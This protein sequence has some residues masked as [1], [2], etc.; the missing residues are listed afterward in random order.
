MNNYCKSFDDAFK[1]FAIR[2][3]LNR[4]EVGLHESRTANYKT[5]YPDKKYRIN[6]ARKIYGN[7][8]K[9]VRWARKENKWD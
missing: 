4:S 8:D 1:K 5:N 6:R 2:H 9:W 7:P 3:G